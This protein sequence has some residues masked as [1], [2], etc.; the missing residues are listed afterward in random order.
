VIEAASASMDE[1]AAQTGESILLAVRNRL[2]RMVIDSRP[3]RHSLRVDWPVGSRLPLHVGGLGVALLAFAP[4]GVQL[5]VMKASRNRFTAQTLTDKK[6]LQ[7]ELETVRKS[8]VRI[9][10]DDY[11]TGEFSVAAPILNA[12]DEALAAINIAGF[13]ARL[14]PKLEREYA[15]AVREAA[16]QIADTLARKS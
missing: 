4:E 10:K 9:S 15:Q 2:E 12:N 3:S 1:L 8:K 14:T 13:T 7:S 5:E 16:K 6:A 11:A